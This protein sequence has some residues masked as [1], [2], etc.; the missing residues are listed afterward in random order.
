MLSFV[1]QGLPSRVRFGTGTLAQTPDEIG[2]LGC[3]RVLV[4]T[5]AAQ[6]H[7]AERLQASLGS[8]CVGVFAEAAMHTPVEVTRS[9]LDVVHRLQADGLVALGGGS[10]IGLSKAIA[11]QTDLPQLAIPTTYAGSEMTPILGQTDG[12]AKSTQRTL[13]VLPECVIYDV[14][15]TYTLPPSA[16]VSSGLNAMA[17]AVEALYATDRNPIT[18]QMAE[19]A[20]AALCESLT[21]LPAMPLDPEI[22]MRALFGSWLSATCLAS[23]SMGLH[24]KL[25]HALGG[26]L[27][28]PHAE[29]HAVVLPH[30]IAYNAPNV[31]H[32]VETISRAI[33]GDGVA[34]RIYDIAKNSGVP[35]SLRELGMKEADILTV[36]TAVMSTPYANPRP[37]DL[38]LL[39]RLLS[40][41]WAGLRPDHATYL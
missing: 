3:K 28:L 13:K 32:A 34:G 14:A 4:V 26:L 11:L 41:A 21:R 1:Y 8:G 15:L 2:R 23:T 30:A 40:S 7:D 24:H 38:E 5:G 25:C 20:I 18:D 22:R 17:H 19:L 10:A 16:S 31:Q 29:T 12:G 35:V 9:A 36:V 37:L 27:D 33:G 39:R 6:R